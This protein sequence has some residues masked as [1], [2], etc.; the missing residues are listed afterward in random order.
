MTGC[1]AKPYAAI[2]TLRVIIPPAAPARKWANV[3]L[4][5][6]AAWLALA[7]LLAAHAALSLPAAAGDVAA[8]L[9][10]AV[11]VRLGLSL[12]EH[13]RLLAHF[14]HEALTDELTGLGNRRALAEDLEA[15]LAAAGAGAP[16]VLGLFDLDG[17]KLYNDTFGHPAGD[18]LLARL[19]ARLRAAAAPA[20]VAYRIGGDE[21]C[22]LVAAEEADA[23]LERAAAALCETEAGLRIGASLGA[24]SLPAD[25]ATPAAALQLADRRMYEEKERAAGSPAR[26]SRDVLLRAMAAREPDLHDHTRDVAALA[27]RVAAALGLERTLCES[28]GRAAELH[29]VGKVAMP[30]TIL[31]K[32]GPEAALVRASHERWDGRGYPDGLAGEEIPLG[33][34]IVAVCDAYSAM[35]QARPYGKVLTDA[36]AR[37]ELRRCSGTQFDPRVVEAFCARR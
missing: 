6:L 7:I 35:R 3:R 22:V 37:A 25:A 14:Q 16:Q 32:P 33:A 18:A 26:Q 36:Q 11:L 20:G 28:V 27:Q 19:S 8:L 4:T 17:F 34:R 9:V 15:A 29:D 23:A 10:L 31:R 5:P 2:T 21:F 12:R 24:V 13:M 30:D 1:A